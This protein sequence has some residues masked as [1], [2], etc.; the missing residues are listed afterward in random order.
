M[1]TLKEIS[2]YSVL[3]L[4]SATSYGAGELEYLESIFNL[5]DIVLGGGSGGGRGV[6]LLLSA[7][8]IRPRMPVGSENRE[9][10]SGKSAASVLQR[11]ARAKEA[12][13]PPLS[14]RL[15]IRRLVRTSCSAVRFAPSPFSLG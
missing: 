9:K 7:G 5:A 11:C 8:A 14:R 1:Q 3:C 2:R 15:K 12:R 6:V 4:S 13:T 10:R